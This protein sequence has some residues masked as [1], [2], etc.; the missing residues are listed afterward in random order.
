VKLSD[1]VLT[2]QWAMRQVDFEMLAASDREIDMAHA[3]PANGR[4]GGK[5]DRMG[6]IAIIGLRGPV[7][8]DKSYLNWL[9]AFLFG[10]TVLE[11]FKDSLI[12]AAKDPSV[13]KI[14]LDINSPGGEA[15]GV[16][17]TAKLIRSINATKPVTAFVDG[18]AASAAYYLA[19]AAGRVVASGK[20]SQVGSIGV[21]LTMKDTREQDARNGV[22]KYEIVSSQSPLKRVDPSTDEGKGNL[23]TYVDA[24]ADIF[25]SDVASYRGKSIDEV[26]A[27]FGGGDV[28]FAVP[29]KAAGMV[30]AVMGRDALLADL[31]SSAQAGTTGSRGTSAK[32]ANKGGSTMEEPITQA[33]VTAAAEKAKAE[34]TAAERARINSILGLPEAAGREKLA[35][36]ICGMNVSVDDAKVILAAAPKAEV[37]LLA[38]AMTGVRNPVVGDASSGGEPTIEAIIQSNLA[39]AGQGKK[40]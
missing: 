35:Q 14:L 12:E 16:E 4:Q 38:A 1:L 6:N 31:V 11:D 8:Q 15:L 29:A 7:F 39:L 19:A 3:P 40:G 24:F 5:F 32:N 26:L 17:E 18:M 27:G 25:I 37:G 22:K 20:S 34:A 28:V 23:Q 33:D 13:A 36:Q 21:V 10:G 30:D 2:R 9:L